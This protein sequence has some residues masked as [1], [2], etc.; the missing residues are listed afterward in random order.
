[1]TRRNDAGLISVALTYVVLASAAVMVM[2]SWFLMSQAQAR[3][4]TLQYQNASAVQETSQRLLYAVNTVYD[5]A[6]LTMTPA[7]LATA[8]SPWLSRD[9]TMSA[10]AV[11][12]I[13]S[14]DPRTLTATI[15]ATSVKDPS[16]TLTKV[17][18]YR[19]VGVFARSALAADDS[20]RPIWTTRPSQN[21]IAVFD[22]ANAQQ[23]AH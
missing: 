4:T 6:W 7:Q 8:G 2:L 16:V 5:P 13:N 17:I 14:P 9:K 23:V 19:A 21:M 12:S 15:T 18:T 1:M 22:F 3:A 20:G 10:V 11:T